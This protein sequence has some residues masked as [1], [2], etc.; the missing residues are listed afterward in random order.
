MVD[1]EVE[2]YSIL[3]YA[4][5]DVIVEMSAALTRFIELLT[6]LPTLNEEVSVTRSLRWKE[7]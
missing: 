6:T 2:T 1:S 4:N 7:D 3:T 5:E